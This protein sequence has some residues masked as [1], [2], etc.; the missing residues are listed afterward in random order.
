MSVALEGAEPNGL[1]S[2]LANLIRA[3]LERHPER[4]ALLRDSVIE[5]EAADVGVVA[6]LLVR[7]GAV[8]VASAPAAGAHVSVRASSSD[9][10]LL[11]GVRLRAGFPDPLAPSGR[12]VIRRVLRGRI[13]IRGLL[14]HPGRLS[15]LSRLLSVV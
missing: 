3:N 13:R 1:A 11:A 8:R 12:A 14:R 4:R 6:T 9:L 2:M 7:D 10:L 5:L 15:R